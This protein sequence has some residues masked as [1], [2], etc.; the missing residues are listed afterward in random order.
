[1]RTPEQL[2]RAVLGDPDFNDL[3]LDDSRSSGRIRFYRC[4]LG[5]ES[6]P[7]LPEEWNF[8]VLTEPDR[9]S[10]KADVD[11]TLR[12]ARKLLRDISPDNTP[13]ILISSDPAVVFEDHLQLADRNVFFISAAT[14]PGT[15]H[16]PTQK[17][18]APFLVSV[19]QKLGLNRLSTLF[20]EPY[21]PG[22]PVEGWRFFGRRRELERLAR[23]RC[24]IWRQPIDL[25]AVGSA[26]AKVTG[27][28]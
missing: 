7:G 3:E 23:C 16:L 12:D 8:A 24:C 10:T 2:I 26:T 9:P 22:Q 13:L 1:M 25:G 18:N 28:L 5:R 15:K 14:L 4:L 17:R 6:Y 19:R 27:V 11:L 20:Y 21:Q